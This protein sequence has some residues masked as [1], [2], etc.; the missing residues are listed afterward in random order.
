METLAGTMSIGPDD[1]KIIATSSDYG[2]VF[3]SASAAHSLF[4]VLFH[5]EDSHRASLK[6]T[7]T[8][9]CGSTSSS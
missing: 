5:P 8:P 9:E 2:L 7:T 6:I 3:T 4:V 1:E